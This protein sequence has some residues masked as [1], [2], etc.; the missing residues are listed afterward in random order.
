M[1]RDNEV[2]RQLT[3]LG[4]RLDNLPR[5]EVGHKVSNDNVSNP[6]TDAQLDTAFPNAY[7]G[8]VGIVDDSGVGLIVWLVVYVSDSWWYEGLTKA[9]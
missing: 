9:V 2:V 8:F 6:P 3:L 4:K 1:H 5:P 7:N